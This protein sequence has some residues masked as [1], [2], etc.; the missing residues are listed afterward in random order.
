VKYAELWCKTNFSFLEGASHADELASRAAQ[1]GCHALAITDRNSLAGIVRAHQAAKTAGLKLLIGAEITPVDGSPILLIAMNLAG[2]RNLSRLITRGRRCAEKGA[3]RLTVAD[4]VEHAGNL[5]AVVLAYDMFCEPEAQA[6]DSFVSLACASGSK[7]TIYRDAFKDRAYLAAAVHL[8]PC[9]DGELDRYAQQARQLRLPL[10]ATNQVHYHD[11]A[12]RPL[13]DVLT[14]V[15]HHTTVADLGCRRFANGERYLKS[16]AQ[17]AQLFAK[18]PDAIQRTIEAA[19]RCAFSLDELRYEYPDELC[20]DGKTPTAYLA[21]LTWAGARQRYPAGIP[22]KV[23]QLLQREL[24]LIAELRYEA[25]F[26]TVWD[27]VVFARDRGILCQ[28]RGSAA[29]SAV[30]YCL[31]ITS[32]DPD[33]ADLLFERF[34]SKE[35]NEAPDIDVDFEHERREEVFQ[36]IYGKYGRDRAGIVAEVITYRPRSAVRDV[37]KALGLSLDAVDRLAKAIDWHAHPSVIAEHIREAGLAP[38]APS[39]RR[40]VE[41][42][43]ELIG[44][45]RHLSQHVGGFVIT[46]RPLSELVPIENAA[47][48]DRTVIEWDKDDLD[49]LGILKVDCLSLGML[50]AIRKCFDLIGP[51]PSPSGTEVGDEREESPKNAMR[52]EERGIRNEEVIPA[53]STS[54]FLIPRSSFLIS[55]DRNEIS[56]PLAP[57]PE[58]EGRKLTLASVPAEDPAVYDMICAADTIGVFQIESRAQMSMLPRLQPRCFYD[59]VVEVAIVRPGPIQGGMVHPFLRRRSGDEP[60]IYPHPI[61]KEVLEK[62]LGVPLFQEQVMRLAIVAAG[63]TPGEADQLRRAMGAWRR[64]GVIEKFRDKFRN[65]LL[66]RGFPAQFADQI[67]EQIKGFGEYGFPESHAASFALLAYVSAWLK[68]HYPAAFTTAIL[69]SQPMGFYASSQLVRDAEAH[70]VVVLPIDVNK[71]E[72]DCT[73]EE[74]TR[75]QGDRETRRQGDKDALDLPSPCLPVSLSPCLAKPPA[76]RLGFRLIKGF[77]AAHAAAL[78]AARQEAAFRS[79]ADIARRSAVSKALLAR[80][81]SADAYRSLGLDR[82]AALWKVLATAEDLPLF[83]GLDDDADP[84]LLPELSVQQHV[85]ADYRA[86]GV[87]LKAHPLGLIRADL[88]RLNVVSAAALGQLPDKATVRVAGL[89]L[90]RQRPPTANGTVFMSLED[91]TGLMNLIIWRRTWERFR[92]VARQAVALFIEGKIERA[93]RVIHVCPTRI[94]DLSRALHGL[95]SGSRDFR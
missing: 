13:H 68:C 74:E 86:T 94:E 56:G 42:S 89:V 34:I 46:G 84:P 16:P 83:A 21:E 60:V 5:L 90:V 77:A 63:F 59:L 31:G 50:T 29:N 43:S 19:D 51:L 20:P 17:M 55:S 6:R 3:C 45:P 47:M 18:Y 30:C 87:S 80:L 91:E 9:D 7:A 54:S 10:V 27:L 44:F 48:L 1:L 11:P 2:Y 36:Y 53:N 22:G 38:D 72:W 88:D 66:G 75:R 64:S 4:V 32:V 61:V 85:V 79:I 92:K 67:Y 26:L 71:S 8:G 24:A 23:H 81:A 69:N 33:R 14:A 62:T 12:R 95:A 15:R 65:G 70:G 73:L 25:F 57:L 41:L 49:V 93:D 40:L 52:N 78:V 39:V 35:R 76:I 58:R 37:G 82:R 28:G